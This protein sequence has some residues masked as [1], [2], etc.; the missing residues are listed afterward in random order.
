MI[1]KILVVALSLTFVGFAGGATLT[2][3][4]DKEEVKPAPKQVVMPTGR[5]AVIGTWVKGR[6]RLQINADNTFFW[7]MVRPCAAPPC[8]IAQLKG[9]W[10]LNG[11]QL[12]LTLANGNSFSIG[13]RHSGPPRQLY[14]DNRQYNTKVTFNRAN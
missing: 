8:K 14:I 2:G 10:R 1:R 6:R 7:A 4:S 9:N 13:W 5:D 3:C 12:V 11:S